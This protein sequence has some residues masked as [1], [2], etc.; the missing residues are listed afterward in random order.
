MDKASNPS[1]VSHGASNGASSSGNAA[2]LAFS[3]ENERWFQKMLPQYPDREAA[4]IPTLHRALNQFGA[5]SEDVIHFVA[6]K[7]ELPI[8]KVL[9]VISFYTMLKREP[10]GKYNV[11]V[12]RTL[13]CALMGA[14]ELIAHLEK[15]LGIHLGET[16]PDGRFTLST[17]ECLA[18]CGTAPVLQINVEELDENLT[19]EKVDS[20]L[21]RCH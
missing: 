5:L 17:A 16:T 4:L 20:I 6:D 19:I 21:A 1:S 18:S 8:S 3:A 9:A 13:S 12:C 2:H 11:Q 10:Q 15:K 14:E 7:L